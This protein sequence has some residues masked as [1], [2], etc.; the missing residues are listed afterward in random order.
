MCSMYY[1][2]HVKSYKSYFVR[3]YG[4]GSDGVVLRLSVVL[5]AILAHVIDV[6]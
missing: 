5:V 2:N 1:R 6:T 3:S 4:G